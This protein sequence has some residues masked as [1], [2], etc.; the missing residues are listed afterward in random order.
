MT[1]VMNSH[2]YSILIEL[3]GREEAGMIQMMTYEL[4]TIPFPDP[5]EFTENELNKLSKG[6][7][8]IINNEYQGIAD[9]VII[10]KYGFDLDVEDVEKIHESLVK[11][12]VEGAENPEPIVR[13]TDE[14]KEDINPFED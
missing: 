11:K 10:D 6:Y 3:W 7:D 1:A 4:S 13:N 5:D 2:I 12:R 14:L 9:E 8:N